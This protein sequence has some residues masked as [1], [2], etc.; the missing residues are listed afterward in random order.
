MLYNERFVTID[1]R[2]FINLFSRTWKSYIE[3]L[4][5]E[6]KKLAESDVYG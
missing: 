3:R 1:E 4:L 6:G 5:W 2:F